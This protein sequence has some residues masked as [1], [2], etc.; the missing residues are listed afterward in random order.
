M[1]AQLLK[2]FTPAPEQQRAHALYMNVVSQARNPWLYEEGGVPDTLDGRF[3]L[4]LLHLF[5]TLRRMSESEETQALRQQVMEVFMEDMDRSVRELGVSDTGVGKRVKKM[6]AAMYGR[7]AAYDTALE[8]AS[9]LEEALERNL[10]GTL[11][12]VDNAAV[13]RMMSY[14]NQL[15]RE[16]DNASIETLVEGELPRITT[17]PE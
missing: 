17:L 1:L 14:I 4:I 12:E 8:Q 6:A 7:F 11:D 9:D 13:K 3:E 16:L 10:Y 15:R 5:L 2:I